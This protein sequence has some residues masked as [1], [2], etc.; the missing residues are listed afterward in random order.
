MRSWDEQ[1]VINLYEQGNSTKSIAKKLR[2]GWDSVDRVIQSYLYELE[3]AEK[4]TQPKRKKAISGLPAVYFLLLLGALIGGYYL[5]PRFISWL[6]QRQ[7]SSPER[8]E[9]ETKKLAE[10]SRDIQEEYKPKA[11]G[12][13]GRSIDDL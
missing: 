9:P 8:K 2:K 3:Q 5:L 13:E 1:V 12:F 11:G 7:T 10:L 6:K 4:E